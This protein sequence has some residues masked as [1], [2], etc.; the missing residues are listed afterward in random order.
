VSQVEDKLLEALSELDELNNILSEIKS[1][2][3]KT[4]IELVP[5]E[6]ELEKI[7]VELSKMVQVLNDRAEAIYKNN[8]NILELL[9]KSKDFI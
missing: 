1:K 2:V 3:D 4:T 6:E 5:K 8:N 9:L 7:E